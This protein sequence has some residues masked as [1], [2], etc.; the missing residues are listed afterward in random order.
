M[1]EQES[2]HKPLIPTRAKDYVLKKVL[3][4][5]ST[6][7]VLPYLLLTLLVAGIGAF[8]VVRLVTGSLQ[9]RFN[10]QL[11]DAGRVV[12]QSMVDYESKRL[13]VL[14]IV[15]GTDGVAENLARANR[16]ELAARVPQI[17]A[18][19]NTDAVELLDKEGREIYGWQRPPHQPGF[20]G[21]D[22]NGADYSQIGEIRWV[23]DGL[24]DELGEKRILLSETPYGLMIFTLGPVYHNGQLVGAAMVGTY[25]D[26]M[27]RDLT[28]IAAARVTLYV[29][30]GSV[31]ETSL[32]GAQAGIAQIIGESPEQY[33]RVIALLKEESNRYPIVLEK[34]ENEVPLRR[35][36]VLGQEYSLAYGDWRIRSQSIG[37]FSVALPN[38]F[39]VTTA[40]TSRNVL[41]LLF[42]AATI[43]VF[44][45]GFILARRIITPLNRLVQTS[46]AVAQ[47]DLGQ[48]TG[49]ER[50]DE[51]GTLAH[52][53]DVMTERLEIRNRQLIEQASKLE[54]ILNSTADGII[55]FDRQ[56]LIVTANP[57]ANR[58]LA[59]A[60]NHFL[61]DILQEMPA[62]DDNLAQANQPEMQLALA[63]A[64][65]QLP[66]RFNIGSQVYSTLLAPVTTPDGIRLGTVV[67][68][69]NVTR[70]AE[71]EQLKDSFITGVSHDLRTPL[72][73]IKGFS[74]LLV[75]TQSNLNDHQLKA[76]E[77]INRNVNLLTRHINQIIE[78]TE[79]QDGNLKLYKERL[80][81]TELVREITL[82]WR[83]RI[84]AKQL[85][86]SCQLTSECLIINGDAKRLAWALDNLMS[87]AYNYTLAG[88]VEVSLWR[89]GSDAC[90]NIVDTG[91]GIAVADQPYLFS[92]FFRASNQATFNVEGVGLGLFITRSIIEKHEGQVWA[93]SKL[94]EGSTFS[95]TLPLLE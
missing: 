76:V 32:G 26:E 17:I 5:I 63:Q 87:N 85:S 21:E 75:M 24:I 93:T 65:S 42:S 44:V 51:I 52:S 59:D 29:P 30:N 77:T 10:N 7:I 62:S 71:S 74:D 27:V 3:T 56:G 39:I 94:N 58:I 43:L 14:R 81:W 4:R 20:Q 2:Q 28:R 89:C 22:R 36:T 90:L 25:L 79:I 91:I 49:I 23:L 88:T 38:N 33:E 57:A 73:A 18:N 69:R 6:T 95:L 86:F 19:S 92:R 46:L 41:S 40:A 9:E 48:R 13:E 67:A 31:L 47:G 84:E 82:K 16:A 1:R 53:F 83:E 35:V 50:H 54:A 78:I 66:K 60:S 64:R 68:L 61:S 34:A 37:F 12:S 72:T 8:I 45:I 11:L 80:C 15:T 70:E 55:L